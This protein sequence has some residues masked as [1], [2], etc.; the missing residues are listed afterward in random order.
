MKIA[1]IYTHTETKQKQNDKHD[2]QTNTD[3]YKKNMKKTNNFYG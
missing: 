1:K 2:T 3:H